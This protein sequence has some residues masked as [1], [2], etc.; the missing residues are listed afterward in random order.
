[1]QSA[2]MQALENAEHVIL[3]AAFYNAEYNYTYR[4]MESMYVNRSAV[5]QPTPAQLR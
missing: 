5:T 4:K 2:L 1:M 3:A